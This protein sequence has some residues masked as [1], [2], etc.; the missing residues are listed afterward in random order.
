MFHSLIIEFHGHLHGVAGTRGFG[1]GR[2]RLLHLEDVLARGATDAYAAV[3]H[4]VVGDAE[5]RLARWALNDHGR[6]LAR[7]AAP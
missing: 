5:L 6:I 3:R 4:L 1:S 2:S 7:R